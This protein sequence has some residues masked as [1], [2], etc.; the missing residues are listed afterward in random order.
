MSLSFFFQEKQPNLR[1]CYKLKLLIICCSAL[2]YFLHHIY[3]MNIRN[4]WWALS[5]KLD[6]N[7]INIENL[8]LKI[9]FPNFNSNPPVRVPEANQNIFS[10]RWF[11]LSSFLFISLFSFALSSSELYLLLI[12]LIFRGV[13]A[14]DFVLQAWLLFFLKFDDAGYSKYL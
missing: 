14:S 8:H 12:Y 5:V 6:K 13:L 9:L 11:P 7:I 2:T 1:I 4:S 3:F 10:H